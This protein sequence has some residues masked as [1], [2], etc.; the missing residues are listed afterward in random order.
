MAHAQVTINA[1]GNRR[2]M[3]IGTFAATPCG[4]THLSRLGQVRAVAIRS[5]KKSKDELKVGYEVQ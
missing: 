4:G 2:T 5:V 3:A 1:I